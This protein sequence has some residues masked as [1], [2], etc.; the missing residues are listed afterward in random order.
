MTNMTHAQRIARL[1]SYVEA[2]ALEGEEDRV[3]IVFDRTGNDNP[4]RHLHVSDLVALLAEYDRGCPNCDLTP[5]P[6]E[7]PIGTWVRDRWGGVTKRHDDGWG[8][9]GSLYLGRWEEM[10]NARG[11]LVP[12][13]P[14]GASDGVSFYR[15]PTLTVVEGGE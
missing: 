5:A 4:Y 6:P 12:C 11:P 15:P 8:T 2:Q 10:W 9:P 3:S 14:W 7:P 1:R 13:L